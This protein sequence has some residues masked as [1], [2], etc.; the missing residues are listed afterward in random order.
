MY[1]GLKKVRCKVELT[2]NLLT[3]EE[4]QKILLVDSPK[5]IYTWISK[6]IIKPDAVL[7]LGR[8]VR[9]KKSKIQELI[10]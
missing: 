1:G 4:L 8:A 2:G 6:G 9:I 5:T 10:A 3:V 7:K